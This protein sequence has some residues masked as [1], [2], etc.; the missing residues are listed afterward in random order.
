MAAIDI[1][2]IISTALYAAIGFYAFIRLEHAGTEKEWLLL[3]FALVVAACER[4]VH[5]YALPPGGTLDAGDLWA[6]AAAFVASVLLTAG[7][8]VVVHRIVALQATVSEVEERL[9]RF[10]D[11][12]ELAADWYWEMDAE[13]RITYLS[14]RVTQVTGMPPEFFIGKKREEFTSDMVAGEDWMAYR[15]S[16]DARRPFRDFVYCWK[17]LDGRT[18]WLSISGKPVFDDNGRFEGYRGMA[19]DETDL[20]EVDAARRSQEALLDSIVENIP[21]MLF[22]KDAV[23]LRYVLIN[24]A[25]ENMLGMSRKEIIGRT[26]YDLYPEEM[27]SG[28]TEQDRAV[29]DGSGFMDIPDEAVETASKGTCRMRTRKVALYGED[30]KPRYLVGIAEDITDR[31][32]AERELRD[33]KDAAEVANRAKSDFLAKMS[34]ELRTPLNAII[35]FSEM[36]KDEILGPSGNDNYTAY[37]SDIYSSGIFLLEL[38]GDLLDLSRIEAGELNLDLA[39]VDVV[40]VLEGCVSAFAPK[41]AEKSLS[42]EWSPQGGPYRLRGDRM[43]LRQ[44]FN[45]LLSNAVKFTPAGG[46]ITIGVTN[47]DATAIQVSV[48]DNGIG[49]PEKEQESIFDPFHQVDD[50]STRNSDGVGLGLSITRTLVIMHGGQIALES[51]PGDGTVVAVTLPLDP[52]AVSQPAGAGVHSSVIP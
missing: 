2:P 15:R 22:V 31:L 38:I 24:K 12:T 6:A 30:G 32:R 37:A 26:A 29:I 46:R 51:K 33:S 50:V 36:M 52:T 20:R 3:P 7:A 43:R 47:E 8:F 23:D 39:D 41:I 11:Y 17:D 5:A 1:L 25:G 42:V 45:N 4:A 49:I 28:F 18:R 10:T 48:V 13:E 40:D 14:E 35:G 19:H 16:I 27:A 44:I 21:T 9:E 34:H